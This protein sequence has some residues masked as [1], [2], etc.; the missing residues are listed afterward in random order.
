MD[1]R[2]ECLISLF[3]VEENKEE[4]NQCEMMSVQEQ[5]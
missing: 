5:W 3:T 4:G 1:L 2:K